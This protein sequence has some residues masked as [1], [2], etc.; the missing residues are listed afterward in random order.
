MITVV[1]IIPQSLSGETNQDSEP[2]LS[3]NP[4][5][6]AQIQA[7]GFTPNPMGGALAP[8][9]VSTDGGATWTL[10]NIV[11]SAGGIGTGD[12]T[13]RFGGTSNRLYTGILD[14]ATGDF[15]VHRATDFTSPAAMTQLEGRSNEDQPY[16]QATT[17]MG[18]AGVGKDRVYIGVNDFNAPGGRTATI[19]Q[20]LDGGVAVPAFSSIRVETRPTVG[21]NGPQVRPAIHGDGTIYAAFYRW[22]A[23]AGSFP[24]NTLVITDAELI[25]VRDDDW[26]QGVA[27]FT[28]LTDPSDGLAG[29]RVATGLSFPFNQTGVAANGQE[30]WGGDISTAVDPRSSSTLYVAFSRLISSVYTL[31]LVRS[32]DRGV[33][34]SS[35]LLSAS[36][37]K[38]PA[39]AVNS[40]GR[41]GLVYQQLNGT[42]STQ[43]WDTHFRDSDDG[44]TWND[45][46]LCSALSQSPARTFSPYTGDYLH[47]LAVG[48]DFY[49]IFSANNT[50]D[51][52]NFPQ[53]VTYQRN[54]DFGSNRLIALDGITTVPASI[55]PFF[56]KV[57]QIDGGTGSDYYVRDWTNSA[58]V[59]DTGLEP[60]TNPVFYAT[61]DV[62]NQRSNIPPTF[63]N[64]EPQD[65]DPQNNAGNFAFARISRNDA[66][67]AETV[68]VEFLVAEFGTGSPYGSVA[69]TSVAF[70]VGDVSKIATAP[71]RLGPTS[72]THLCLGVQISTPIDPFVPPGLVGMTPGWPTTDLIVMN[73]NN[74]AQRNMS[75]H[76]GLS[77][78]GSKH[79]A[80]IRNASKKVRDF[81][82]RLRVDPDALAGFAAPWVLVQGTEKPVPLASGAVLVVEGMKPGEARWVEFGMSA[83]KAKRGASLPVDFEELVDEK[84]VVNGYRVSIEA[85]TTQRAVHELALFSK[86]VFQRLQSGTKLRGA[87]PVVHASAALAAKEVVTLTDYVNFVTTIRGPLTASINRYLD[88]GQQDFDLDTAGALDAFLGSVETRRG[89]GIF[90]SHVTLLNK[91]DVGLILRLNRG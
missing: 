67:A 88:E 37:A 70:A 22:L 29:R 33:T 39:V 41:V 9:Y 5:N 72:S 86:A 42:G 71:W 81:A 87:R 74:K 58:A 54:H 66:G 13:S 64:D 49:G 73:D 65:E 63:V 30:R 44:V 14:G 7:S 4:A 35:V 80:I 53:G 20:S 46:V 6:P 45:H 27:P 25:V 89:K 51:P 40:L 18:G 19:E 59:H 69:T 24:A 43:R 68:N 34:W 75:V 36:N 21:Q 61:S 16:V 62:W 12:I 32:L 77:G 31:Q 47:M 1:N 76:Y 38:N 28:A 23:T 56:F 3:V 60:S 78:F 52:A 11:P 57:T 26:G 50:P 85:A 90:A 55:D 8:I 91:L 82:L 48:K 2:N 79:Y 17:V 84:V 83:F 15:E 10:N